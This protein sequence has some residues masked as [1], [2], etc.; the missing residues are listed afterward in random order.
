LRIKGLSSSVTGSSVFDLY[1]T[2]YA[3]ILLVSLI[4]N[5]L[6]VAAS[7]VQ[8]RQSAD[9]E[10]H[11]L[12]TILS[13]RFESLDAEARD[14]GIWNEGYQNLVVSR[15]LDW[16]RGLYNE[17]FYRDFGIDV[18]LLL[19]DSNQPLIALRRGETMSTGDAE[20][21]LSGPDAKEILLRALA[22]PSDQPVPVHGYFST[23]DRLYMATAVRVSPE[24]PPYA[25]RSAHDVVLV[26]MLAVDSAY[27]GMIEHDYGLTAL[28]LTAPTA[29]HLLT[30]TALSG[31]IPAGLVWVP[32]RP[33]DAFLIM[34]WPPILLLSLLILVVSFLAIRKLR[35]NLREIKVALA[36]AA[37]ASQAKSAFLASISHELRTPLNAVIGFSEIMVKQALGPLGAPSYL[38][39]AE[40]IRTSGNHLLQLI[41]DVL[42]L[43]NL[44]QRKL[45]LEESRI[46]LADLV[47]RCVAMMKLEARQ[48]DIALN[49][50]LPDALPALL[51]DEKRV[52]QI[53][54]HV[55]SNAIKFNRN[56]GTVT[57]SSQRHD[58]RLKLVIADTG[59]GMAAEEIPIALERFG[60]VDSKITRSYTGSGLGLPLARELTE[61]HGGE[62]T[63]DSM[64]NIGT[65]VTVTFPADRVLS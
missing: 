34:V 15:D 58:H 7:A 16:A 10:R 35:S 33:G 48:A 9:T 59:I 36:A 52:R 21:Y 50:N 47:T 3:L 38:E 65:R 12:E 17:S 55:L 11:T 6:V 31:S 8:N 25:K 27:L 56:G 22:V 19:N 14:N 1:G 30:L 23:N 46:D 39:F 41:D 42:D 43:N 62:L 45:I 18:L 4:V 40:T 53:L 57:I 28:S 13:T 61:L 44:D 37:A 2:V 24:S 26:F 29:P 64:R 54:L 5:L 51:A 49:V 32:R 63:I 60:Q 20:P